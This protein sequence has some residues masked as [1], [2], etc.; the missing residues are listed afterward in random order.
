VQDSTPDLSAG[1]N[2]EA[3]G[4]K[5]RV[6]S[7]EPF[8]DCAVVTL[9][10]IDHDNFGSDVCLVTP[11]DEIRAAAQRTTPVHTSRQAALRA[12][13]RAVSSS[14]RWH[15]C[16]T[17]PA[18]RIDLREWQLE[19][20]RAALGGT[21]RLLLADEVG[22]GK[23]I[24]AALVIAELSARDLVRN[25]LVLT[26][27]SI[28]EQWAS[29]LSNR[30]G[31]APTVLDHAGLRALTASLP[32]DV[33]PWT[34][35][36]VI[37]SSIDL[38]KRPE[39]RAAVDACAFDLLVVDEA[40]H[41][42]PGSDRGALVAELASRT[43]WVVLVTA[44]PH[45]GDDAAYAFLQGLGDV[46][47]R[48]DVRVFRRL[49]SDVIALPPR[50]TKVIAVT[51]T[52]AERELLDA[53]LQYARL[54]WRA[55]G[56]EREGA[57]L[58]GS[59]IARRA[60]SCAHAARRTLERRRA[61]LAGAPDDVIQADLPWCDQEPDD[62]FD[63]AALLGA[64]G[65]TSVDDEWAVLD[66]LIELATSAAARSSKLQLLTRLLRRTRESVLVF[67][68]YRDTVE[69]T[70][71]RLA[72]FGPVVLLH[73]GLSPQARGHN[74]EAFT[75]G[76]ARILVATDTA[77]EGLNLQACCRL[78]VN[79]E[80]PWNPRR[81]EQRVGRLARLGQTRVVHALH[82][83]HRD[84]FEND[85]LARV[86]R[87]RARAHAALAGS[88]V[89][90]RRPEAEERTRRLTGLLTRGRRTPRR[91]TG[92]AIAIDGGRA[93]AKGCVVLY[94]CEL[95]D[96]AGH[97]V[98]REVIPLALMLRESG[99]RTSLTTR[100]RDALLAPGVCEALQ[101]AIGERRLLAVHCLRSFH[102]GTAQ[103]IDDLLGAAA[104]QQAR[105]FQGS[106]F[107]RRAEQQARAAADARDEWRRRLE[108]R[109]QQVQALRRIASSEPRL[110]AVW[111]TESRCCRE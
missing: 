89:V 93:P 107:E 69:W 67:S 34:T 1:A 40:H 103:R 82:L 83:A 10:G 32:P 108:R 104:R 79:L 58:V 15:D 33:N 24:Q 45:S 81:L 94:A 46:Q 19:P 2:V 110:I 64:P 25:T 68:E 98:Q 100:L 23:T 29:E 7:T 59:V 13:A 38:V 26:P 109:R 3:R 28:R 4:T 31:L 37:V 54:L 20:A 72:P 60:A 77:G 55:A 101:G 5:W 106:L 71:E 41:L 95:L 61:L 73:G 35:A 76:R 96:A 66:R 57:G 75:S 43:P 52:A 21:T 87:R 48:G 88:A 44:T 90:A 102:E 14:L 39:V 49:A 36:S 84:S 85:V 12:A 78:V 16:W 27:A 62:A 42:T 97:L 111:S 6:V 65:L 70:G 22:L 18:A 56:T 92:P 53:T 63:D 47:R 105:A 80:L 51:P 50:R 91:R 74:V 11:F 9:R 30:F 99:T 8:D 86:E 17:A